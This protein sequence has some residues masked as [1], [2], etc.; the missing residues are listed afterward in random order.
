MQKCRLKM[1]KILAGAGALCLPKVTAENSLRVL[2]GQDTFVRQSSEKTPWKV[3]ILSL[4]MSH[5]IPNTSLLT[6]YTIVMSQI[7]LSKVTSRCFWI[8]RKLAV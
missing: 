8:S 3:L 2:G 1:N 5:L 4:G 6:F 7:D